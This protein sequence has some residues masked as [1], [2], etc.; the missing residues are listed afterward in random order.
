M[1]I[2]SCANKAQKAADFILNTNKQ[3]NEDNE[4]Q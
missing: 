2:I 3:N 1:A 4:E